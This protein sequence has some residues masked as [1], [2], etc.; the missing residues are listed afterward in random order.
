MAHDASLGRMVVGQPVRHHEPLAHRGCFGLEQ[1]SN[2]CCLL[3]SN[4]HTKVVGRSCVFHGVPRA[5][6][7]SSTYYPDMS[8]EDH[9]ACMRLHKIS[10]LYGRSSC[11]VRHCRRMAQCRSTITF[12]LV[13]RDRNSNTLATDVAQGQLPHRC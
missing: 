10:I 7:C 5:L 8:R 11:S 2:K 1:P 3:D 6:A 9:N 4:V 13:Y 12:E